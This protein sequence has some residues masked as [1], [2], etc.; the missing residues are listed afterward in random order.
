[1]ETRYMS[2]K[3]GLFY[4]V[5]QYFQVYILWW[6]FINICVTLPIPSHRVSLN[7][8][9]VFKKLWLKFLN[10]II[11]W[12]LMAILGGHT[13]EPIILWT[14]FRLRISKLNFTE[15]KILWFKLS[16]TSWNRIFLN[17]SMNIFFVYLFPD[18]KQCWRKV[19]WKFFQQTY[20]AWKNHSLSI[21]WLNQPKFLEVPTLMSQSFPLGS[22]FKWIIRF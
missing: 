1:M 16:V 6:Q 14:I 21:S 19:S 20:L 11:L 7:V 10:M 8:F 22:W 5:F 4:V 2:K 18:L 17:L 12:A 3:L 13:I 9:L 15:T